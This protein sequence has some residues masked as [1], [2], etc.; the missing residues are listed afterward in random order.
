MSQNCEK[1]IKKYR[2]GEINMQNRCADNECNAFQRNLTIDLY[3]VIIV[4]PTIIGKFD[5]KKPRKQTI[6]PGIQAVP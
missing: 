6:I 5:Q 3:L 1:Q 4:K 2:R